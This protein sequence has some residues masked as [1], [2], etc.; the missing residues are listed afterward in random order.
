[1]TEELYEIKAKAGKEACAKKGTDI[2]K[3]LTAKEVNFGY[4][5]MSC[6]SGSAQLDKDKSK[7][8]GIDPDWIVRPYEWKKNVTFLRD[9]M[10]HAGNNEIGM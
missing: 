7:I 10:R 3:K 9:F 6:E 8:E 2:V 5:T 4:I 1:M